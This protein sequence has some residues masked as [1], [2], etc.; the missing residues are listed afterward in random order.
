MYNSSK[1]SKS[2]MFIR[3]FYSHFFFLT[4]LIIW[5]GQSNLI[6]Q[7][8]YNYQIPTETGDGWNTVHL[9][10][11]EIDSASV[12]SFFRALPSEKEH[13]IHSILLVKDQSL[14]LEEYFDGY[15]ASK[16]H[17]I[18][19]ATKSITALLIGIALDKGLI[20]SIDDPVSNYLAN[21]Q[22][23]NP[24]ERKGKITL[25]HL[26]TMSAGWECND[27]NKQSEGQEDKMYKKKDWVQFVLDLPM[28]NEPGDTSLYCTGGIIVLG[29]ILR[30]AS[31]ME[32][33]TFAEKYLF[34]PLGITNCQWSFFGK[35][36]KVDTG[37]HLHLAPRDMA[38][39][40]QL[41]LNKGRWDGKT[42]VSEEW[43]DTITTV[44]TNIGNMKYGFLWW[45]IPFKVNGKE[46]PGICATG[47]GGQYIMMV[48]SLNLMAVFTGGNFNSPKA[49]VPF[50]IMNNV[51]LP[52]QQELAPK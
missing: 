28:Q 5:L 10:A 44:H 24:D 1:L 18:R 45:G 32:V 46:V 7:S 51:I 12:F 42:I 33:D 14:V 6:A 30:Q 29:E 47:N 8:S 49:Q 31:G 37:G 3:T 4:A 43:I 25:R 23:K 35:D 26:L 21:Y 19:S 17:D 16:T 41:V 50:Q 9:L 52:A 20:K 40:G 27:W 13:G 11:E 36:N 48:P 39:I 15:S 22:M 38:K 2:T 34:Q